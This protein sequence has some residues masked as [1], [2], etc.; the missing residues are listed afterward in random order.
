MEN[1]SKYSLLKKK[2]TTKKWKSFLARRSSQLPPSWAWIPV[3]L[4]A[5]SPCSQ[6]KGL[7]L[8]M[9][10]GTGKAAGKSLYIVK[11][12]TTGMAKMN[13][14]R[15]LRRQCTEKQQTVLAFIGFHC[16]AQSKQSRQTLVV[17]DKGHKHLP[18]PSFP[19]YTIT[20]PYDHLLQIQVIVCYGEKA[21]P[22]L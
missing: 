15:L 8:N 1:A 7:I 16:F 17:L 3:F 18:P 21:K 9:E 5:S 14:W 11:D 4:S 13:G 22:L 12:S 20:V 6:P 2:G 10:K 19:K